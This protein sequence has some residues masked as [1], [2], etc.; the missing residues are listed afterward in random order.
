M[1]SVLET[2]VSLRGNKWQKHLLVTSLESPCIFGTDYFIRGYCKDPKGYWWAF[3]VT[4]EDAEK[5]K[6][7]SILLSFLE[8]SSQVGLLEV[9]E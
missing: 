6:Q 8:D 2:E 5:I 7:L 1:L 4:T 3:G 9:K